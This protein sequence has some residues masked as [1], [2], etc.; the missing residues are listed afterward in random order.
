MKIADMLRA[1]NLSSREL[2][3]R[4]KAARCPVANVTFSKWADPDPK[5]QPTTPPGPRVM[6]GM[7]LALGVP[8]PVVGA[9]FLETFGVAEPGF[10]EE[11]QNWVEYS[12][13][14]ANDPSLDA[15]VRAILLILDAGRGTPG[16]IDRILDRVKE[17][18]GILVR[19]NEIV[20]TELPPGKASPGVATRTT[21][22]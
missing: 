20:A 2:A 1:S 14:F 9:A 13:L 4:S 16:Q 7:A 22:P 5:K 15:P 10:S 17:M 12:N 6:R 11:V 19:I 21:D 18:E 8:P 3:R